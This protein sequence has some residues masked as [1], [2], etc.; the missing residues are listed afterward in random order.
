VQRLMVSSNGGSGQREVLLFRMGL[1]LT[2]SRRLGGY[3]VK[4]MWELWKVC[5]RQ[6]SGE[7]CI[8]DWRPPEPAQRQSVMA[9]DLPVISRLCE[10]IFPRE[11]TRHRTH[12]NATNSN[13]L[14]AITGMVWAFSEG[15]GL[16]RF[17]D[18]PA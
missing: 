3:F 12:T 7:S 4:T 9:P 16:V 14:A 11:P 10:P 15:A 8:E 1:R 18:R 5:R 17:C 2:L 13:T 6:W